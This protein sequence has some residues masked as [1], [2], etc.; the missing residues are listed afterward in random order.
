MVTLVLGDEVDTWSANVLVVEPAGT[1]TLAGTLATLGFELVRVI[2]TPPAGAEAESRTVPVML[3]PRMIDSVGNDTDASASAGPGGGGGGAGGGF[4]VSA[5]VRLVLPVEA[6]RLTTVVACGAVVVIENEAA[7]APPATVTLAGTLT[8]A[9]FA[10]ESVTTVPPAGAAPLRVTL[11]V[12]DAPPVT[13]PGL[14][15]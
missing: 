12:D 3:F 6:V 13:V 10:L 14:T 9:G 15:P 4:T 5:A 11:P 1:V 2:T 8:T 7:V